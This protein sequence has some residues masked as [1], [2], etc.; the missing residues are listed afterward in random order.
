MRT[1]KNTAAHLWHTGGRHTCPER[2]H[3]ELQPGNIRADR[4]EVAHLR[5]PQRLDHLLL[6][7]AVAVLWIYELGEQV[8]REGKCTDIDPAY[9]RQL[10]VFQLGWRALRR[11]ISCTGVP[12]C[13]SVCKCR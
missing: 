8:L 6:A 4:R 9:E 13:T 11:G 2:P 5:D 3:D 7:I 10:S 12:A 1:R